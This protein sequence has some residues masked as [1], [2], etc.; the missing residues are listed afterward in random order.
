MMEWFCVVFN[1]DKVNSAVGAQV[2]YEKLC[3]GDDSLVGDIEDIIDGFCNELTSKA[4]FVQF[5]KFKGYVIIGC[6]FKDAEFINDLVIELAKKH[7]LSF[8]EPQNMTYQY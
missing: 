3:E 5:N 8:Y 6:E 2:L 4:S 7:G 1:T